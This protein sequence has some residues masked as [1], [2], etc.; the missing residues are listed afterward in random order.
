MLFKQPKENINNPE[1]RK[2]VK[3]RTN[4]KTL[5]RISRRTSLLMR[6]ISLITLVLSVMARI[7]PRIVHVKRKPIDF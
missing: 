6:S 2:R 4:T 1:V 3:V 5:H 7:S